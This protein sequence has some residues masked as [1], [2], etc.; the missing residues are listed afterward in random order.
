MSRESGHIVPFRI[1]ALVWGTL[2]TLTAITV[3]V[4]QVHLGPLNVWVALVIASIKSGL[5]IFF[6]M[7]MKYE[8]FYYKVYMFLTLVIL[9][10]FIGLTF[11]DVIYR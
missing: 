11:T 4:S 1:F 2:L 9:A 6:F 8:K 10:A 5:V 3:A 7:H